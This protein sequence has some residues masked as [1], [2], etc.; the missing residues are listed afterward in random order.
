MVFAITMANITMS[1][2]QENDLDLLLQETLTSDSLLLEELALDSLTILDLIDSLISGDFRYS[3]LVARMGYISD[4]IN[5]GRDF[6]INQYGFSGGF[7]YYHK[8]GLFADITGYWNSDIEPNY[9]L[10]IVSLGYMGNILPKWNI[11]TSYD[12][13]FYHTNDVQS[14]LYYP[15]TEA[16]SLST[17]YDVSILSFGFDYTYLFG[18]ETAHRLRPNIYATIRFPDVGFIDEIS[19][20]PTASM[21]LGNQNIYYVNGNYQALRSLIRKI[22]LRRFLQIYQY[23]PELIENLF[24]EEGFKNVFGIMNYSFSIPVNF[25]FGNFSFSTS[26]FLNIPVALPGE[27]IDVTP[28]H[29]FNAMALY[30]IPFNKKK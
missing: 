15:L 11:I 3:S 24:P 6:G 21:L 5:A 7:S 29:Y 23:N 16:L 9:N 27:E 30:F 18:K 1:K 2:A 8:T 22:G 26:Y 13:N 28:N 25:K 4:I 14:D 20:F 12:H 17:Y 10:T 19:I